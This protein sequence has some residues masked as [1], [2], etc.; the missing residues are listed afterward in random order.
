MTETQ[1]ANPIDQQRAD[2]KSQDNKNIYSSSYGEIFRKNFVAGLGKTLGAIMMYIL[3]LSIISIIVSQF[4][5]PQILSFIQNLTPALSPGGITPGIS[6]DQ[7]EQM[8]DR[9]SR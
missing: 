8:L 9:F 3:F 4:F 6:P 1:P 7:L 2:E 5:L